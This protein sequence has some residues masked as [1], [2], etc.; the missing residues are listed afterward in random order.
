MKLPLSNSMPPLHVVE[1][2]HIVWARMKFPLWSLMSKAVLL[3][4]Y[5]SSTL[6]LY[7][8]AAAA[9]PSYLLLIDIENKR[10]TASM[11]FFLNEYIQKISIKINTWEIWST[12]NVSLII[13]IYLGSPY[14]F[15]FRP[16][17]VLY[18]FCK[19]LRRLAWD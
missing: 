10:L 17:H 12:V 13:S 8:P 15:K 9:V 11:I 5:R 6:H 1:D 18:V 16:P 19:C 2:F 4:K 7:V 3:L 14:W